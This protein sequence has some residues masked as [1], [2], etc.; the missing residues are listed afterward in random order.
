MVLGLVRLD[1]VALLCPESPGF[2]AQHCG[3]RAE[4]LHE[5]QGVAASRGKFK[6]SGHAFD[7]HSPIYFSQGYLDFLCL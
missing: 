7:T 3:K 1:P 2:E 6:T 4:H 5:A